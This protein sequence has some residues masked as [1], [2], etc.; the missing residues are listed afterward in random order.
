MTRGTNSSKLSA[1]FGPLAQLVEQQTLNLWVVGSSPTRVL[2]PPCRLTDTVSSLESSAVRSGRRYGIRRFPSSR[3]PPPAP[4]L[5]GLGPRPPF[6]HPVTGVGYGPF[7]A[8]LYNMEQQMFRGGEGERDQS[9]FGFGGA[10]AFNDLLESIVELGLMGL[11]SFCPRCSDSSYGPRGRFCDT[12]ILARRAQHRLRIRAASPSCGRLRAWLCGSWPRSLSG[13]D[14]PHRHAFLRLPRVEPRRTGASGSARRSFRSSCSPSPRLVFTPLSC[15]PT[16]GTIRR[17]TLLVGSDRLAH[18]AV[19]WTP[20]PRPGRS[21]RSLRSDP[22]SS[23]STVFFSGQVK[24]LRTATILGLERLVDPRLAEELSI[25]AGSL[26]A[27]C[28]R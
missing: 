27:Q 1:F 10:Y 4:D 28:A 2:L 15:F 11:S 8:V 22:I 19:P 6:A 25:R 12:E 13:A 14:P 17:R 9:G 18:T 24:L 23:I 7:A 5:E 26:G 20:S 21:I 3:C 16:S